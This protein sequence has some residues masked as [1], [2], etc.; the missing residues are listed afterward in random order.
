MSAAEVLVL[1]PVAIAGTAGRSTPPAMVRRL[2]A[3]LVVAE[4]RVCPPDELV[5]ALWGERAPQS[6][7][8]LVRVYVSQLRKALPAGVAVETVAGGY[9]LLLPQDALDAG[10]FERLLGECG[11][12]RREGNA[13]LAASLAERALA[14]WRGR[15]FGDL[16]YEEFA[17]AESE[18]LEELRLVALEERL[19]ARLALGGHGEV[20]GEAV[21][22]AAEQPF[23]E[24]AHELA[25]LAL[26]RSGRQTEALDH[27][28][29]V[30]E[31]LT[32]E[33]GLEPGSSLREL[34]RRMLQQDSSLDLPAPVPGTEDTL[35]LAPT[36][37]VG[38]EAE[39]ESLRAL[40][41]RRD[42]RLLVLTG[43]GGSGK[44][45]L[46][47]EAA[48]EAAPTYANGAALVELAPLRDPAL[49]LPTIAK[50]L[51]VTAV[52]GEE[53]LD[54]LV[55]AIRPRELL[56]VLDNAEHLREAAPQFSELVARAPLLTLL[57]TSRAV[58]HLSGEH[59]FPVPPLE[60]APAVEL[61]EQR[62]QALA[63][64]FVPTEEDRAAIGEV[65]A[66]VDRLP[67]AIELAAGRIG[68][69]SLP[70]LLER[71]GRRLAVL[72]GGPRDLPA[73]Q[74]TLR[75]TLDWSV[76]LLAQAER[77]V[78]ARLAVFPGGATL[79]AAEEVCGA[80]LDTLT[81]LV[82]S[83]LVRRADAGEL[84]RF[85]LLETVR[86]HALEL[87]GEDRGQTESA[88]LRHFLHL[89]EVAYVLFR[90][91]S[92]WLARF[93][94]ELDNLR[95]ALDVAAA[96]SDPELEV[97]LAGGLWRF[98]WSR[99]YQDEG[100]VRLESA[101][102]RSSTT[103]PARVRALRGLAGLAWSRGDLELA[104]ARATEALSVAEAI[105]APTELL[106]AR[107]VL[108]IIANQRG[109]FETAR[110]HHEECLAIR[111]SL[112]QE[113]LVEKLNLGIVAMDSGDPA[114]AVP[115][116]EDV[117]DSHRRNDDRLGIGFATINLGQ[118]RYMLGDIPGSH[119]S[120]REARDAFSDA[121]FRAHVAHALQGLAACEASSGR[122]EDAARLLGRAAAELGEIVYSEEYFPKLAREVEAAARQTLGD[123]EFE[124]AF[125][126]GRLGDG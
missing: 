74:Q 22:L 95:A 31:R 73:R 11:A 35:P 56:L 4:R 103:S 118:V 25:M 30:R 44:T 61:F 39:L 5:E 52:A 76:D 111:L 75:E 90:E 66:R 78:L 24:R 110:H 63:A 13:A 101:L 105:E 7:A 112:G 115:F 85:G 60:E 57:V 34:Q 10:R 48:R 93:D 100:V 29:A 107:T 88:F 64:A 36:P 32:E 68:T 77:A 1:G 41:G 55:Q 109:D 69:L 119:E 122:P 65:C 82:E 20:L 40:L 17:R 126:V 3:A 28:A 124:A 26:Y 12:A 83:N 27:Y 123:E 72:T 125:T 18:R 54:T 21:A 104:E 67:L 102:A 97:Q 116:F 120:Y 15:A 108:G 19:D 42:V 43:A 51:D 62:A 70:A 94:V 38:R 106:G 81:T 114:R 16:A 46:A 89:I 14:L 71:L 80:T 49:V 86:E 33:L 8:K 121:G 91:D 99:G 84:V 92:V 50:R 6:A 47:L 2:L 37:L 59:V 98:W 117:L 23:R 87:L 79:E 113:P 96:G 53:L 9:A 45:R 58:L